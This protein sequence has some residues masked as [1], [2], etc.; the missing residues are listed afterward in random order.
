MTNEKICIAP[1]K[2]ILLWL[3]I[4]RC[5][6]G[7]RNFCRVLFCSEITDCRFF[8][9]KGHR[10]STDQALGGRSVYVGPL[11][12][13]L[14]IFFIF[15]IK[16]T[17]KAHSIGRVGPVCAV[18]EIWARN[19]YVHFWTHGEVAAFAKPPGDLMHPRLTTA[20]P[21]DEKRK[22]HETITRQLWGESISWQEVM[23]CIFF[24]VL[25]SR[26][27]FWGFFFFGPLA[28]LVIKW[29][30]TFV[31]TALILCVYFSAGECDRI[32]REKLL[33]HVAVF[34]SGCLLSIAS[35]F[36]GLYRIFRFLVEMSISK[37]RAGPALART[38][39]AKLTNIT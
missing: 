11:C 30:L 24:W 32:S 39:P 8:R 35:G 21:Y 18:S 33:L 13:I 28:V 20:N 12:I 5:S 4:N 26:E 15:R 37:L 27:L 14:V 31:D 29:I 34:W 17:L 19:P 23:V 7:I 1:E 16:S 9:Y 25:V 22:H 36:G 3:I 38:C 2:S 6:F 10:A